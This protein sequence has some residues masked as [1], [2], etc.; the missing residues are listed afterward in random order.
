VTLTLSSNT[1][2]LTLL[3][4]ELM[5]NGSFRMWLDGR[6]GVRY[7]VDASTNATS[8]TPI[9]THTALSNRWEFIDTSAPTH[10]FRFYRAREE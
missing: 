4:A 10:S 6:A 1:P 5:T 2:P 7:Q 8:W 9:F 3:S